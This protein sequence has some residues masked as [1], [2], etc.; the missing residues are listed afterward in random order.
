ML[1]CCLLQELLGFWQKLY[2]P[3]MSWHLQGSNPVLKLQLLIVQ[4]PLEIMM[5]KRR[6]ETLSSMM[7]SSGPTQVDW[8]KLTTEAEKT[9]DI[10]GT[11]MTPANLLFSMF[12]YINMKSKAPKVS[13]CAVHV[14]GIPWL[15]PI[16]MGN[17]T[18]WTHILNLP[19]FDFLSWE[20]PEPPIFTND[21][22]YTK[23]NWLPPPGPLQDC[24]KFYS[25]LGY[26]SGWH[27][28]I[29]D[30]FFLT[31]ESYLSVL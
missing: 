13:V 2:N 21:T 25:I 10:M 11:P 5:K 7:Q 19:T 8:K 6:M 22:I 16:S 15:F 30:S 14:M 28:L 12:A 27:R 18:Y 9:L 17:H 26:H 20:D 23:D 29:H 3:M 31:E 24:G 4:P 1:L